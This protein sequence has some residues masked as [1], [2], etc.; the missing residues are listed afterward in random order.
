LDPGSDPAWL[1]PAAERAAMPVVVLAARIS[2]LA[3]VVAERH[4]GL[5]LIIDHICISGEAMKEGRRAQ[6]MFRQAVICAGLFLRALSVPGH[7]RIH[8]RF[9][10]TVRVAATGEPT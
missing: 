10:P 7:D 4:P 6:P 2:E 1:W 5:T 3:S 8:S 9:M